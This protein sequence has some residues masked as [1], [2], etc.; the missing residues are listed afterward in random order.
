MATGRDGSS[1]ELLWSTNWYSF[2]RTPGASLMDSRPP[3]SW[4]IL[5]GPLECI[6]YAK[7]SLRR[8]ADMHRFIMLYIVR[9]EV[10][11]AHDYLFFYQNQCLGQLRVFFHTIVLK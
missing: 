2:D 10:A 5:R 3:C 9:S 1:G 4:T 8:E 6:S 11:L 7:A